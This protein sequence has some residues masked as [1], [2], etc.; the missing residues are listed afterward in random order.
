MMIVTDNKNNEQ[1]PPT[2][3]T[4]V[5]G[6]DDIPPPYI[7]QSPSS[8]SPSTEPSPGPSPPQIPATNFLNVVREYN[9][10]R[11]VYVVDPELEIPVGLLPAT[12]GGG[13]PNEEGSERKNLKLESSHGSIGV[14]IWLIDSKNEGENISGSSAP[15]KNHATL[16]AKSTSGSVRINLV[17]AQVNRLYIR[18]L[19]LFS[20]VSACSA[21][22][23]RRRRT[24]SL[25]HHIMVLSVLHCRRRSLVL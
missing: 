5:G 12:E 11:G 22:L 7:A 17:S 19:V 25:L 16:E 24:P 20:I 2:L 21:R 13:N 8:P 15:L 14:D 4:Q 18:Y 10:I 23:R 1:E 3:N 6:V 9:A